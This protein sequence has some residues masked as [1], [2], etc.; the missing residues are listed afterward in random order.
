M[1]AYL[2]GTIGLAIVFSFLCYLRKDLR[3]VMIYSGLLYL[4]YGFVIFLAIKLL[5]SDPTKAI[6]P[7]YWGPPSL[8]NINGKT[9]GYGIEDA[10][11]S[12][13]AGG[14]AACLYELTFKLRVTAKTN[15]KLRKGHALLFAL[16]LSSVV[17]V[18]TPLNAIYFFIFLQFF[19][20]CAIIWQRRDLFLHALAGGTIFLVLYGLLFMIFKL[21]FPNF[22][23]DYYHL[24][25]TSHLLVAGIP[26]EEYLYALS[27]G[28][29]WAP[30]YEYEF[31]LKDQKQNNRRQ[32]SV[33]RRLLIAAGSARR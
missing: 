18:S 15:K 32:K 28:M 16:L 14:I 5:S 8:F 10:L 13:F 25:R 2:I 31:R 30:I 22:V 11:F 9:G 12:F 19:G 20:A 33:R 7:G 6:T 4:L 1:Y 21:L 3:R 24:Q 23:P 29:M 17:F 27:L 26:L